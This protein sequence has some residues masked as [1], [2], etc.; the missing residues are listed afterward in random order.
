[1]HVLVNLEGVTC[2]CQP[3]HAWCLCYLCPVWGAA[4]SSI[5]AGAVSQP[6]QCHLCVTCPRVCVTAAQH[7]GW[8]TLQTG[9]EQLCPQL[10]HKPWVRDPQAGVSVATQEGP[11]PQLL[12]AAA[13]FHMA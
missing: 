1:M 10:G 9:K 12:K 6:R 7:E 5:L 4:D 13:A 11:G 8:L 3:H 2:V